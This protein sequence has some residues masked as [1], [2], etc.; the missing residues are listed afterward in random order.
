MFKKLVFISLLVGLLVFS[1]GCKNYQKVLKSGNN[2]LKY[3]TGIDLFEK[4][5]YNKALQFFD[6]LR[7]VYRGTQKGENLT[8]LTAQCYF[9]MHD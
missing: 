3:E 4:G 7:A 8:Y 9:N 2:D 6:I 1:F 5:D